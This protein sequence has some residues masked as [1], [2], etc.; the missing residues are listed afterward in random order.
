MPVT[1]RKSNIERSESPVT[2]SLATVAAAAALLGLAG[3]ATDRL[4]AH[5]PAGTNLTGEWQLDP[6]LSDDPNHPLQDN[7]TAPSNMRHRSG[8]GH[9]SGGPP[10][11]GLPGGAGGRTSGTDPDGADDLTNNSRDT[12]APTFVRTLWQSTEQG[13]APGASGGLPAT[14]GPGPGSTATGGRSRTGRF[15]HWLDAPVRMT[16]RQDGGKLIIQ[17]KSPGGDL[18]IEE[19]DAGEK[20]GIPFG[21]GTADRA[22]GWRGPIFVITTKVKDGPTKEDDYAL[23]DEGHLIVSTLMTGGHLPKVDVKRVYD[24]ISEAQGVHR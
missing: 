20:H 3:C 9:G 14:G 5:P 10:S 2:R 11:F 22:A 18:Q 12:G 13:P 4:D 6:N 19:I 17:T 8:R 16:V 15:G 7:G 24:R 21:Q 23:D 1:T